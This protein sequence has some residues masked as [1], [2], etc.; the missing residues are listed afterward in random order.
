M[1]LRWDGG[2]GGGRRWVR[3]IEE[4]EC[5]GWRRKEEEGERKIG[6]IKN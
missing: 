1:G 2:R 6:K 3:D 5:V 4:R